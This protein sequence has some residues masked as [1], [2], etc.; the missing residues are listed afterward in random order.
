MKQTTYNTADFIDP[1]AL[2]IFGLPRSHDPVVIVK[3][4]HKKKYFYVFKFRKLLK[5]FIFELFI[6]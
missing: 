4:L 3:L 2:V 6:F 5:A 1:L